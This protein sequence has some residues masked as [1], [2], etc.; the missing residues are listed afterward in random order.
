MKL[1]SVHNYF[2]SA[3]KAFLNFSLSFKSEKHFFFL[4]L[5]VFSI[6]TISFKL[7]KH[8]TRDLCWNPSKVGESHNIICPWTLPQDGVSKWGHN[9][10]HL[11]RTSAAQ[12]GFAMSGRHNYRRW[13]MKSLG[14]WLRYSSCDA[15]R[16]H[17]GCLLSCQVLPGYL[18]STTPTANNTAVPCESGF[19]LLPL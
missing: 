4:L 9:H 14:M 11:I 13:I 10:W 12:L 3:I 2:F 16:K 1:T 5:K 18:Q 15:Q 7:A 8:P 17:F 19:L 6:F